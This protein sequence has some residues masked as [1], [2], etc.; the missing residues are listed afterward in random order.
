MI[1]GYVVM[2]EAAIEDKSAKV[3]W[4]S[5]IKELKELE[6]T[7]VVF[8]SDGGQR[9]VNFKS[10]SGFGIHSYF[11]N[12]G[13]AE[14]IGG[15]KL[16]YPTKEGYRLKKEVAKEDTVNIVRFLN[17]YGNNGSKTNNVA[18]LEGVIQSCMIFL[19]N[20]MHEFCSTICIRTDSEYVK[21]GIISHMPK[22]VKNNWRKADGGGVKNLSY[23][24]EILRL[25][26]AIEANGTVFDIKWVKGHEDFGNIIA[27]QM[28]TLGL[29]QD[30]TYGDEWI[31]RSNYMAP[32][33]EFCPLLIDSKLLYYPHKAKKT[34]LR[35][36]HYYHMAYSNNNNQDDLCDMGRNLVD[37]SIAIIATVHDNDLL[38]RLYDK[39]AL[40]DDHIS[41]TPKVI[42]L[43][44]ASKPNVQIEMEDGNIRCLEVEIDKKDLK[45]KTTSDKTLI[46]VL[47]PPRNAL[48][49]SMRL[50]DLMEVYKRLV[51]KSDPTII[52]TDITE[53]LFDPETNGKGVTKYKFKVAEATS[54]DITAPIWT[55]NGIVDYD[56]TLTFGLDLPRRRVFSNV[57][58]VNPKVSIFTW[59][60]N[61]HISYFGT[62]IRIDD[63]FGV[64]TAEITNSV[65]TGGLKT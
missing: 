42:D 24:K 61:E 39:C 15:F 23:W 27:D 47:D 48:S 11:Y 52:E 17:I 60:E 53:H 30:E 28:A 65:L 46:T 58:D 3:D 35:D 2:L 9:M 50:D 51:T 1:Q 21:E 6:V 16:D 44:L 33:L 13:K 7:G 55:E 14:G 19:N 31:E 36:G 41:V 12:A 59:Y 34:N 64:W 57:K 22:W 26:E 56:F 45:I 54:I 63:A 18:E 4:V 38:A 32:S 43:N 5:R 20:N 62:I 8:Y 37:A 49:T 40:L 10:R 25:K 29:F